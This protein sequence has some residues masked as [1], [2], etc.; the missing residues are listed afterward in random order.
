MSS[1]PHHA[2]ECEA[3]G[4]GMRF[5]QSRAGRQQ[6]LVEREGGLRSETWNKTVCEFHVSGREHVKLALAM[7]VQAK[8][9]TW[10][11]CGVTPGLAVFGR[12]SRWVSPSTNGDACFSDARTGIF[13]VPISTPQAANTL[14]QHCL[15]RSM[16]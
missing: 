5:T 1:N 11:R 6:G 8:N 15:T 7:W 4:F 9:V 3:F 2:H 10:T 16:S 12:A 13:K 14:V